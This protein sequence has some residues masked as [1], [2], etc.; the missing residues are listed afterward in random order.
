MANQYTD[1]QLRRDRPPVSI[2]ELALLASDGKEDLTNN[3]L[4]FSVL[5]SSTSDR[6]HSMWWDRII[7]VF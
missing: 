5:V 2:R 7:K 1:T 3:W 4:Q 6:R